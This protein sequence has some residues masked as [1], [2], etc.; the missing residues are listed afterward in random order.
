MFLFES[1]K[2]FEKPENYKKKRMATLCKA[3]IFLKNELVLKK[4]TNTFIQNE[5]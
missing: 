5:I 2:K 3:N 1:L 4:L